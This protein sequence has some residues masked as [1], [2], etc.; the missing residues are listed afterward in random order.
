[1]IKEIQSYVWDPKCGKTG[2]D[3]PLKVSDHACVIGS[4]RVLTKEG[5][6]RIDQLPKSGTLINYDVNSGS[7][8]EDKYSNVTLT[9]KNAE[10]FELELVDGSV[11]CATS[12]HLILTKEGY[13]MLQD[14]TQSD[15]VIKL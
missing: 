5:Y 1:M 4:T 15:M 6:R 13:K 14:L 8:E 3:K 2:E 11:L 10:V 7:F 12:D 9:R